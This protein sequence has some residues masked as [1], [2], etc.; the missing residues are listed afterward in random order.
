MN[1]QT[2]SL[3]VVDAEAEADRVLTHD[4]TNDTLAKLL[5]EL[6]DPEFPVALGVIYRDP[7]PSFEAGFYA[8]HATGMKRTGKVADTLRNTNTWWVE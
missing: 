4:E 3:E 8:A 6:K 7:A 2:I 5:L 1:P